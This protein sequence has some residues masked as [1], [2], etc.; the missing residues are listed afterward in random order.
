MTCEYEQQRLGNR[1]VLFLVD[2]LS[3]MMCELQWLRDF[4][5]ISVERVLIGVHGSV[6]VYF[7]VYAAR[8]HYWISA[9]LTC[10]KSFIHHHLAKPGIMYETEFF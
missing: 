4:R 6:N 10:D 9:G 7:K 2:T 5:S 8:L 1:N 3:E